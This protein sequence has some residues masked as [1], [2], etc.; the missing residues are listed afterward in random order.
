MANYLTFRIDELPATT[1][2]VDGKHVECPAVTRESVVSFLHKN[3]GA[4]CVAYEI[5][6]KT[7]KPHFQ[8]WVYTDLS[9]QTLANRIK[10][11]WPQVKGARGRSKGKYSCAPV[12][13]PESYPLYVLKGTREHVADIV[14]MQL[15]LDEVIDLEA[16][17]RQYWSRDTSSVP[18]NMHVVDE[19]IEFYNHYPWGHDQQDP[20]SKRTAVCEFIVRRLIET[21]KTSHDV[22]RTRTWVNS[23]C[24]QCDPEF[25]QIFV[26][27]VCNRV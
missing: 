20:L 7:Q 11:T 19:A 3:V 13:K 25:R 9:K 4:H 23:V 27:E 10:S 21:K 17:H 8:G 24:N 2:D 5:S 26:A 6:D 22:Y 18:K 14:S 15:R 16:S 1:I 12:R